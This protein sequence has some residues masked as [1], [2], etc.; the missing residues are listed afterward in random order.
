[1]VTFICVIIVALITCVRVHTKKKDTCTI[2]ATQNVVYFQPVE[3]N[4]YYDEVRQCIQNVPRKLT[5]L[6]I[7]IVLSF[8][9]QQPEIFTLYVACPLAD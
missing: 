1:M 7:M 3:N 5:P 2:I 4:I 9:L 8:K 6:S